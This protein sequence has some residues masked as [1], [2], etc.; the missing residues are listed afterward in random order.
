MQ[1]ASQIAQILQSKP[2]INVDF[3]LSEYMREDFFP[4]GNPLPELAILHTEASE[5]SSKYL[6]GIPFVTDQKETRHEL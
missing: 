1:T 2:E 4:D 3:L 6:A 5:Y